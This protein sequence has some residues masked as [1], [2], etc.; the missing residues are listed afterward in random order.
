MFK[1][2]APACGGPSVAV[3]NL[4]NLDGALTMPQARRKPATAII[5]R[6]LG[7][8]FAVA[9]LI[10][11]DGRPA[12]A[13]AAT[14]PDEFQ[15]RI[16]EIARSLAANPR[17]KRLSQ[18][19]REDL[20]TFV[21]GNVLFVLLHELGHATVAEFEL[22]VLGRQEA[23]AD[24]FAVLRLLDVRSEFSK[25]VLTEA[26]KGWFL[27]DR[28]SRKAGVPLFFFDD[29]GLDQQ[30]AFQIA[31]L[32]VGSDPAAFTDLATE[33]GM[34]A[35][36]QETCKNDH[37]QAKWA[38]EKALKPHQR[39]SMQPAA[40][41]DVTYGEGNGN[42]GLYAEA[43]R[44]LR[45]LDVVAERAAQVLAWPHP[46]AIEMKPC[47]FINAVWT[48]ITHTLTVCYELAA[49]FAEL[50]RDFNEPRSTKRGRKA[51]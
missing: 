47:G 14:Q 33:T 22:P 4:R 40:M 8:P 30:R 10:G 49:D 31:C 1:S 16:T 23:A 13:E 35:G 20:V 44:K 46:F 6:C 19:R 15:A 32:M 34:P 36:R 28:R 43:F 50:Y 7:L 17:L 18:Q 12:F 48:G 11:G 39:N 5:G 24:D 38:W 9:V 37:A 51:R 41:I 3:G 42:L 29:H 26:T 25:R 21:T 2:A 45:M 27:S